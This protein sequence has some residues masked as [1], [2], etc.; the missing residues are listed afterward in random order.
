MQ[1]SVWNRFSCSNYPVTN[2]T[3]RSTCTTN[4]AQKTIMFLA[5]NTI[6]MVTNVI[7]N[8]SSSFA[9][10]KPYLSII[11]NV[12]SNFKYIAKHHLPI[13][14]DIGSFA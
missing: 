6:S 12:Y 11:W 1:D 14:W 13:S 9:Q 8:E 2:L 4:K 10:Q 5:V 7:D 3:V